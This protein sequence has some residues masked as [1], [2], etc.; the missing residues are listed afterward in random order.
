MKL[1]AVISLK[2]NYSNIMKQA[3]KKTSTFREDVEK[4]KKAMDAAFK[5]EQKIRLDA[6]KARTDLSSFEKAL[7][8][9]KNK[10]IT[11]T[12]KTE[13]FFEQHKTIAA[14]INKL[15]SAPHYITIKAR[16][17]TTKALLGG[18]TVGAGVAVAGAAAATGVGVA[19]LK[20]AADLERQQISMEHFIGVN[21]KKMTSAQVKATSDKYL[22][23]LRKNA[24]LTPFETGDVLAAG[25][26][27]IG[28]ASGDTKQ[29]MNILRLSED[30]A[31]LTPGKTIS[32]AMEAIADLKTG[33]TE[34]MKEFGFKI[35]QAQI[36]A[37]G[38]K[39]ENIKN[40]SGIALTEIFKGGSDKLS[41]S[42]AGMWS[43]ITG[44]M[45][46]GITDMGVKTLA[47][48]KPQLQKWSDALSGGG[49]N[50]LFAAGSKLMESLAN[51]VA[52]GVNKAVAYFDTHFLE[53]PKF[54][55]L[56]TT[57]AKIKFVFEEIKGAWDGWYE[58]EGRKKLVDI[59]QTI[60]KELGSMMVEG[61]KEA[62]KDYPLLSG[63]AAGAATPGPLPAKAIVAGEIVAKGYREKAEDS[64]ISSGIMRTDEQQQEVVKQAA[65]W[66]KQM[67]KGIFG[68]AGPEKKAIGM[69]SV[70]Y[71]N[72]PMLLHQGERVLTA[73]ESRQQV[74]GGTQVPINLHFNNSSH[75]E[76]NNVLRI[77]RTALEGSGYNMA[78]EV[79]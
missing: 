71:D 56:P 78:P 74:G 2:D 68:F 36:Q 51:S 69:R 53:N 37:A 23:D 43:T 1:T 29:A 30:M 21:N 64:L 5:R 58:S 47:T 57:E 67:I 20:G 35:S 38:G 22:Q 4:T 65:A 13:R 46:S 72:Y 26:R 44:T 49:A 16:D 9:I 73:Q 39:M 19:S 14:A 42:A 40:D 11:L 34:R 70:P 79:G 7:L 8:K 31:A 27:A 28:I 48:L 63:L 54:K 33:E 18:A 25:T 55:N 66:T 3:A 50:K 61:F 32:D 59:G 15:T 12:A 24:D 75:D 45:K 52:N 77:I 17:L 76:R 62:I 10:S 60:G 41:K 6:Q